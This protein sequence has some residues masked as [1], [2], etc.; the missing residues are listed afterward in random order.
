MLLL[1]AL[2]TLVKQLRKLLSERYTYKLTLHMLSYVIRKMLVIRERTS[3]TLTHECA[4]ASLYIKL[5]L[6]PCEAPKNR[7]AWY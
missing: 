4:V 3:L 7:F 6:V 2:L 1:V 5:A